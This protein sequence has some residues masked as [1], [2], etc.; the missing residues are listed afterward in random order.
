[1]RCHGGGG[2]EGGLDGRRKRCVA[3][4]SVGVSARAFVLTHRALGPPL[5]LRDTGPG[6][7]WRAA[8]ARERHVCKVGG[9]DVDGP[10]PHERPR[11]LR[12]VRRARAQDT[13]RGMATECTRATTV[14]RALSLDLDIS[15]NLSTSS[16]RF[17]PPLPHP[18]LPLG[19]PRW[20][21]WDTP[22]PASR[23]SSAPSAT[24]GPTSRR[25]PSPRSAP[26]SASSSKQTGRAPSST[27]AVFLSF[28]C[29]LRPCVRGRA[30]KKIEPG[31]L[32]R[33]SRCWRYLAASAMLPSRPYAS[34]A[35]FAVCPSSRSSPPMPPRAGTATWS[36]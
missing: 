30:V 32:L 23:P 28:G 26:A 4:A 1:M 11:G 33:C 14:L 20:A 34:H 13:R 22:T 12:G 15:L 6:G 5:G 29:R 27:T 9:Q 18:P 19:Y 24:P 16:S 10:P 7:R 36:A 2:M 25:T 8:G 3:R 35:R 17:V 31:A 21:S